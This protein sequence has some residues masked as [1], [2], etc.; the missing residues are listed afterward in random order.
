MCSSREAWTAWVGSAMSQRLRVG[1]VWNGDQAEDAL[2]AQPA[3]ADRTEPDPGQ[4]LR[5]VVG[6][7]LSGSQLSPAMNSLSA[8][9]IRIA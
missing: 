8:L 4:H 5:E 2:R 6:L 7:A 9:V 1:R 3:P